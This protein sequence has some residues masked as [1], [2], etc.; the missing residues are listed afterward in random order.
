MLKNNVKASVTTKPEI[1][2]L[3]VINNLAP[4]CIEGILS[5]ANHMYQI[6]M[7]V[8]KE[9]SNNSPQFSKKRKRKN[10]VRR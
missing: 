1:I 3:F 5:D 4:S 7:N 2:P 6:P 8:K 9:I 10:A